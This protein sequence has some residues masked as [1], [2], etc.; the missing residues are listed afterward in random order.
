MTTPHSN[1]NY[2]PSNQEI[3]FDTTTLG[4]QNVNFSIGS[5]TVG[6]YQDR[7]S[8]PST[9]YLVDQNYQ[10]STCSSSNYRGLQE[11]IISWMNEPND[12]DVKEWPRSRKRVKRS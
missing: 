6:D 5:M 8:S 9:S 4:R 11:L 7:L 10:L 2:L 3:F 1:F 12:Y